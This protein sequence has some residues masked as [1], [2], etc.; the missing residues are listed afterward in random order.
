MDL[1]ILTTQKGSFRAPE[2]KFNFHV[3]EKNK[4]AFFMWEESEKNQKRTEINNIYRIIFLIK[5]FQL[6]Y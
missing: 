6:E 4:M 5:N 3:L 2:Y 1:N